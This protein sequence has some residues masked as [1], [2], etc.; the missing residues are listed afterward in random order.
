MAACDLMVTV[1]NL[2]G[3]RQVM[4]TLTDGS[5]ANC[6][7]ILATSG[8]IPI[9]LFSAAGPDV[10][11]STGSSNNAASAQL[12]LSVNDIRGKNLTGG[13]ACSDPNCTFTAKVLPDGSPVNITSKSWTVPL[14]GN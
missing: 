5:W 1:E 10:Q 6:S 11:L 13:T 7:E 2:G 9:A 14:P 3:N 12:Y 8:A 4:I